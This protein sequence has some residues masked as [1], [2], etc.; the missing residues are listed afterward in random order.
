MKVFKF[1]GAS[2]R[3][4][5]SIRN[6]SD[7]LKMV[8]SEGLVIVV[9][10]IGKTT[11]DLEKLFDHFFYK[12]KETSYVFDEIR[13]FHFGIIEALFKNKINPV[14]NELESLFSELKQKINA[15]FQEGYDHMYDQIVSYGE[16]F[17]SVILSAWLRETGFNPKW[18]DARKF[19]KT[20]ACYREGKIDW[21]ETGKLVNKTFIDKKQLYVT[22][23]FIASDLNNC[24]TTLG[25]EGSDY[26]AAIIAYLIDSESL[27][28]WKDVPGVLNAD[29]KWFDQTKLIE[30]LSY[31]D[32]IELAY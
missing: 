30:Q 5:S 9:S 19:I 18:E 13:R 20:D 4:V 3:D 11:N 25:R 28:I 6:V 32:A 15:P 10:A 21:I 24:T 1:G 14:F 22:Q 12:K 8:S 26:T 2:V 17:S 16:L 29:P 23:G 27:T 7:I 31:Q